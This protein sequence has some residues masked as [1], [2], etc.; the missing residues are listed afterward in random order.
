MKK[1]VFVIALLALFACDQKEVGS[2]D[3]IINGSVVN[4]DS[5]LAKV[6]GFGLVIEIPISED[7]N[8]SDTLTIATDGYYD[9]FVGRERAS[10]YLEKGKSLAVTLDFNEF[11]ESLVYTGDLAAE[12]NYLAAKY[13]LSEKEKPFR[14]IYSLEEAEFLQEVKDIYFTYIEL[15][16]NSKTMMS[17]DF[18]E[19][20]AS[21]LTYE[22]I[23]NLENYPQ[24]HKYLT[25]NDKLE[26]SNDY[27]D[28]LKNNNFTDTLAFK[29]SKWYPRMLE[30]HFGRLADEHVGSMKNP[31]PV[32]A[33]LNVLNHNLPNGPIKDELIFTKLRYGMTPDAHLD[34]VFELFKTSNTDSENLK[35]ITERY[36]LLKP[37]QP[38]NISPTFEYENFKGGTSKLSDFEGKYVYIDVWATW[39]GP[40]IREIPSLK[41]LEKDYHNKNIEFISISIDVEK[42]YEKW[43]KMVTEKEL[44][45]VQLMAD[46]DWSSK[47]V[48]E[49]GINGIPRFILLDTEGK[50]VSADAMRP[51]D[52]NLRAMLDSLL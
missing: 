50:I 28:I 5:D 43:R 41:E 25:S 36:E 8:F 46:D 24:Y 35:T 47:F 37:L 11:D 23:T 21:E 6:R 30:A 16:N 32:L 3:I 42:D 44:G 9:L 39:C 10:I 33:Y 19:L 48:T 34:Q 22:Y 45:G 20:E 52:P 12:N 26:L 4:T 18:I 14:E 29:N 17:K 31:S 13:L 1:I 38:G 7:G 49:Y 15:F 51:S 2:S 27:Y 40:C